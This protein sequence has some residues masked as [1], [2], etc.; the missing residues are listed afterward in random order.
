VRSVT[1]K[2]FIT[3]ATGRSNYYTQQDEPEWMSA[4]VDQV[5]ILRIFFV[6]IDA[7]SVGQVG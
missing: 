7:S 2:S 4:T 1:T 5:P 6:V 3:P